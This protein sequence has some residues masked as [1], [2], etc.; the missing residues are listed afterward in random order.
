MSH[1]YFHHAK[2]PINR[3]NK[4]TQLKCVWVLLFFLLLFFFSSFFV[5]VYLYMF[6]L[7]LVFVVIFVVVV[8]VVVAAAAAAV[9]VVVVFLFLSFSKCLSKRL[10]QATSK[11]LTQSQTM[12]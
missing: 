1:F 8:V 7:L 12:I 4:A 2:N 6:M 5:V 3:T 9:F 11:Q 10:F